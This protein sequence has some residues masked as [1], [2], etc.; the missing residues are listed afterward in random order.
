MANDTNL[1]IFTG[2]LGADP[3]V[4]Y[5]P[6]GVAVANFTIAVG[7]SWKDRDTGERKEST[8]WVRCT[9]WRK[10]AELIGEYL[11]KGSRT[12]ITGKW[13]TRSW[14]DKDGKKQYMTECVVDQVQ[15]LDPKQGAPKGPEDE[16][17]PF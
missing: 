6:S 17:I 2:R 16:D 10:T 7:S 12:L 4:S 1:C 11:H 8:Q 13:Q 14:D 15:F 9:A 5:T 3:E